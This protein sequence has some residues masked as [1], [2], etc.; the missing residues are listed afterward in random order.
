VPGVGLP[1]SGNSGW[2]PLYPV[3]IAPFSHVGLASTAGAVLAAV[4]Q[5]AVISLLWFGFLIALPKSR[6]LPLMA[7]AAVFPGSIYY[8]AIFPMSLFV[9]L[10]LSGLVFI[11]R[12]N[13]GAVTAIA[14]LAAATHPSGWAFAA[15]AAWS[16]RSRLTNAL[17]PCAAAAAAVALMVIAQWLMTGHWNAYSLSEKGR[18]L[19]VNN[20]LNTLRFARSVTLSFVKYPSFFTD[21]SRQ[22]LVQYVQTI[23]VLVLVVAALGAFAAAVAFGGSRLNAQDSAAAVLVSL[24]WLTPL[25]LGGVSLYRLDSALLPSILLLRYLPRLGALPLVLAAVPLAF[26]MDV[27][28]FRGLLA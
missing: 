10:L 11:G 20:P 17:L 18:G 23:V 14:F 21:P 3:L 28:F 22:A 15:C 5:L 4:F 7:L 25:I 26:L 27:V 24:L 1:W 12:R 8:A 6:S 2:F 16:F 9:L 19:G 13:V